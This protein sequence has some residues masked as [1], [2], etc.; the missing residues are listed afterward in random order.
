MG[1]L[2]DWDLCSGKQIEREMEGMVVHGVL[3]TLILCGVPSDTLRNP[4]VLTLHTQC[5]VHPLCGRW[6]FDDNYTVKT[7]V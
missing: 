2:C 5:M 6:G 3:V 1:I 4:H 7:K